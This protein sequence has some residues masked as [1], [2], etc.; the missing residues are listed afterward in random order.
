MNTLMAFNNS[1]RSA[2]FLVI[3]V[4]NLSFFGY[5]KSSDPCQKEQ[6]GFN[7]CESPCVSQVGLSILRVTFNNFLVSSECVKEA[8]L[9]YWPTNSSRNNAID[10]KLISNE[11]WKQDCTLSEVNKN[12][13]I[14]NS[15]QQFISH[16]KEHNLN[17]KLGVRRVKQDKYI[18]LHGLNI[19]GAYTLQLNVILNNGIYGR[20]QFLSQPTWIILT[21]E[22]WLKENGLIGN[23][24]QGRCCEPRKMMYHLDDIN[25]YCARTALKQQEGFNFNTFL[26]S[27]L[28]FLLLVIVI[29]NMIF[30]L[31]KLALDRRWYQNSRV[32][33]GEVAFKY[34]SEPDEIHP[35][36]LAPLSR[37]NTMSQTLLKNSTITI[38]L[39]PHG[40]ELLIEELKSRLTRQSI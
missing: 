30:H 34:I 13:I 9:S 27:L 17:S 19:G 25:G 21:I 39:P 37:N 5:I 16:V 29:V 35:D 4:F 23:I 33:S 31:K 10:V 38:R 11:V 24:N 7:I 28:I 40:E 8:H 36:I 15:K 22:E 32:E 26:L 3:C 18:Y 20:T 14:S 1:R 6:I 12:K 2:I